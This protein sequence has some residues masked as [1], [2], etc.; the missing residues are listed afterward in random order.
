MCVCE[1]MIVDYLIAIY[2]I[3]ID[4]AVRKGTKYMHCYNRNM[5]TCVLRF[6][7]TSSKFENMIYLNAM[8]I[9][10]AIAAEVDDFK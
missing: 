2:I 8:V 5:K 7:I 9:E 6:Q 4:C 3:A 10:N 1:W